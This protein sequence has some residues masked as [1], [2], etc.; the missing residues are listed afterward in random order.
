M[1]IIIS[2]ASYKKRLSTLPLCLETIICQT[3]KPNKILLFL[4]K[5]YEELPPQ[6]LTLQ[7]KGL[8]IFFVPEDLKPHNKYFYAMQQYPDDIIITLDDDVLY[9]N[10]LVEKLVDSYC[11]NPYAVSAGRVHKMSFDS[12]GNILPYRCWMKEAKIYNLPQMDLFA[13]G[14]GGILYPPHCM[15]KQLFNKD[16]IKQL[17]LYGD[18]IWLKAMQILKGTP[19]VLISQNQ[20]HPIP[21]NGTETDGLFVINKLQGRNDIYIKNVF[22][23]YNLTKERIMNY[24][25]Y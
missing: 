22:N 5:K 21:I 18:D 10:Y 1:N 12:Y 19:V 8:K 16:K 11:K 15:D 13:N 20:Q 4:D 3:V 17:C 24:E 14:V 7:E 2:I 6:I 25:Q 9:P 23:E